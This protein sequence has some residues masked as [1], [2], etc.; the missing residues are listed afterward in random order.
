MIYFDFRVK[1]SENVPPSAPQQKIFED[2]CSRKQIRDSLLFSNDAN[3]DLVLDVLLDGARAANV[4]RDRKRRWR[5]QFSKV[6][7]NGQWVLKLTKDDKFILKQSCFME[8]F[9]S[10]HDSIGHPG[11]KAICAKFSQTFAKAPQKL[12]QL[13]VKACDVCQTRRAIPKVP[14]G[15]AQKAKGI[16]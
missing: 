5:M 10:C 8:Q 7:I 3:Y 2:F 15:R 6:S 11:Y 1:M 12:I 9:R 4:D 13:L 14:A 16:D